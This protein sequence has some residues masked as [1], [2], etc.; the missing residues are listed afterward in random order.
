MVTILKFGI[1]EVPL[2][3]SVSN[4]KNELYKNLIK[5]VPPSNKSY[6]DKEVKSF[7]YSL[8]GQSSKIILPA[9]DQK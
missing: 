4:D 8:E 3:D 5:I 2:A 6:F 1:V 9:S 7:I